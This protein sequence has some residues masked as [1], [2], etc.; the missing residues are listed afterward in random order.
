MTMT[1]RSNLTD[2]ATAKDRAERKKRGVSI[3]MT[4]DEVLESSWGRPDHLNTTTNV[5]GSSEQWVYQRYK[6]GYL[7]F[8]DGILTSIS[9]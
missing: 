2:I 8:K 6:N 5:Y 3:G 9:N 1:A 4:K 7:Y